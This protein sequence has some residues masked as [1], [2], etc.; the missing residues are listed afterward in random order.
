MLNAS[1]VFFFKLLSLLI[2]QCFLNNWYYYYLYFFLYLYLIYV[3]FLP[4]FLYFS[5]TDL[6]HNNPCNYSARL[7]FTIL[8][9]F[10][11]HLKV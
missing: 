4:H 9:S 10:F 6:K 11:A 2:K 8:S 1:L 5:T 7:V 3:F